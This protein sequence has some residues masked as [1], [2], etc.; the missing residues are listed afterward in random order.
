L[1]TNTTQNK[2]LASTMQ[3]STHHHTPTHHNHHHTHNQSRTTSSRRVRRPKPGAARKEHPTNRCLLRTQQRAEPRPGLSSR[4]TSFW[5]NALC[6]T[7]APPATP[8]R[9][10]PEEATPEE[11]HRQSFMRKGA[12]CTTEPK[13]CLHDVTFPLGKAP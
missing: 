1:T 9:Q 3:H 13:P 5:I 10:T 12:P 7:Q 6:S 8:K 2:M 11:A 4:P